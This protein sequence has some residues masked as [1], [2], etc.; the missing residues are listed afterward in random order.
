MKLELLE[1]HDY[2]DFLLFKKEDDLVYLVH[3]VKPKG[4]FFY[5]GKNGRWSYIPEAVYRVVADLEDNYKGVCGEVEVL[6]A[7]V[8][9][10]M[11]YDGHLREKEKMSDSAC[12][13]NCNCGRVSDETNRFWNGLIGWNPGGEER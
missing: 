10:L 6:G 4:F 13:D 12:G 5:E 2:S 8:D 9:G 3:L 7:Q 1:L 11:G